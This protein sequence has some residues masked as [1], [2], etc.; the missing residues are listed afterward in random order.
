MLYL[1]RHT[2][3]DIAH[4]ICYGQLDVNL[5]S[6]FEAEAAA[7]CDFLPKL[8]LVIASPSLRT[9]RLAS[10]LAI[11]CEMKT[12]ARLL[13][14]H[15]GTWEGVAWSD[16]PRSEIDAWALDIMNHAPSGGESANQVMLRA[17]ALI[18]EIT[19]MPEKNIALIS[20]AGTMRAMLAL[21]ADIPLVHALDW[22]ISYGAVIVVNLQAQVRHPAQNSTK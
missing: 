22:E 18:R 19:R 17:D 5:G 9:E 1:I 20:H 15:F 2:T 7:I 6:S 11:R 8:D 3:P 13:E 10:R 4:G 12:D 14:K 16:I 21:L